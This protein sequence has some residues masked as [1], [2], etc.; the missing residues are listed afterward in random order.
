MPDDQP[1]SLD[2]YSLF[3]EAS[4]LVLTPGA[5]EEDRKLAFDLVDG[6]DDENLSAI[7]RRTAADWSD[8]NP[9]TENSVPNAETDSVAYDYDNEDGE[10][11]YGDGP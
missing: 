10:D 8:S 11:A 1:D 5:T 3:E 6:L 9:L 7:I 4:D 2:A